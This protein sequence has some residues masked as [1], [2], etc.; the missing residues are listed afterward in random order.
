MG[1]GGVLAMG[2]TFGQG[3]T[4]LSTLSLGSAISVSGIFLGAYV[5]LHWQMRKSQ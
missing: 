5:A 2:C 4:G 1:A 3:L